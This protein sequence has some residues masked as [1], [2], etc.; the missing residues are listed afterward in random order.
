MTLELIGYLLIALCVIG[1]LILISQWIISFKSSDVN[2]NMR[3]EEAI[4]ILN[5]IIKSVQEQYVSEMQALSKKYGILA[6][7]GSIKPPNDSIAKFKD[8]KKL[9]KKKHALSIVQMM[10]RELKAC[11]LKFYSDRGLVEYIFTEMDNIEGS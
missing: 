7:D 6:P 5:N 1:I 3:L 11:L 8:D 10:S 9:V 4:Y 2:S